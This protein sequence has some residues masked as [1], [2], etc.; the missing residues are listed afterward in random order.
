MKMS[1]STLEGLKAAGAF[2][3]DKP[4]PAPVEWNGETIPLYVRELGAGALEDLA[5][6]VTDDP[7]A[8]SAK[9]LSTAVCYDPDGAE[10]MAFTDAYRLVPAL[11]Q[12]ILAEVDRVNGG[13]KHGR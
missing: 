10:S 9:A 4:R 2:V 6:A 13:G 12:K 11:S 5:R 8:Y 7:R 3:S 1:S